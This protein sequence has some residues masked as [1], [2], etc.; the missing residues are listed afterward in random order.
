MQWDDE[1]EEYCRAR[2]IMGVFR[3]GA[4]PVNRDKDCGHLFQ[5]IKDR[6]DLFLETHD[7]EL[8]TD[9]ANFA[10]IGF[11]N[12]KGKKGYTFGKVSTKKVKW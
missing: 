8:L 5:S 9:I 4:L 3:Y 6:V 11:H 1:F 10:R 2:M 12:C 7:L